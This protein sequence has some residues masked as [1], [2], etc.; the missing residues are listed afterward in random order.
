M[1]PVSAFRWEDRAAMLALV[2]ARSFATLVDAAFDVAQVPVLVDDSANRL[3]L[4]L[5]R[6]NPIAKKMPARVVAVV[7]GADGYVSPDWYAQREQV[8]T[9]NYESVE[10]I[11]TLEPTDEAGLRDILAK[12]GAEH[13]ARIVDKEPWTLAKM[14]PATL[15][16]LVGGIIGAT[17]TIETMRGTQKLSQNKPAA[18]RDG[19]ITALKRSASSRDRELAERMTTRR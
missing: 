5:A 8:P 3:L 18:D 11:G 1:H 4:H 14:N 13:E 9:W 16:K 7:G 19:V 2:Q 10:I 15:D 12:L 6:S 17:L